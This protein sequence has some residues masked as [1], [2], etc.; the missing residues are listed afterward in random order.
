MYIPVET[1]V[2]ST[3][4]GQTASVVDGEEAVAPAA[5]GPLAGLVPPPDC[6]QIPTAAELN[7]IEKSHYESDATFAGTLAQ[8][9]F[10][11]SASGRRIV[12][13]EDYYRGKYCTAPTGVRLLYGVGVRLRIGVSNIKGDVKLTLPFIAASAEVG[14]ATAQYHLSVKGYTGTDISDLIPQPGDFNVESY[15]GLIE[16]IGKIQQLIT[17]EI[18]KVTPV[19][20]G[21]ELAIDPEAV[22]RSGVGTAWALSQISDGRS[23]ADALKAY[24]WTPEASAAISAVY[25]NLQVDDAERPHGDAVRTAQ[26]LLGKLRLR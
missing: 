3:P 7:E 12:V 2:T 11:A 22:L 26:R 19:R 20:L 24:S 15:V 9:L 25:A 8:G 6:A 16:K 23:L 17:K 4:G 13:V 5:D 1:D 10:S 14:A 18:D 21:I